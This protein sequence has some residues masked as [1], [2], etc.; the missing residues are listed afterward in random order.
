WTIA[1]GYVPYYLYRQKN[2]LGNL[3]NVGY[4]LPGKDSLYNIIMMEE[5]QSVIGLG[6]GA[7]S[8]IVWPAGPEEE[9]EGARR[10]ERMPNPK[11]PAAYNSQYQDYIVKK[12]R[13]LDEAYGSTTPVK[14]L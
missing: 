12:L 1:H 8:K 13:L 6:C 9:T 4:A 14:A 10:I 2:I 11:E 7:V 3:E 5:R